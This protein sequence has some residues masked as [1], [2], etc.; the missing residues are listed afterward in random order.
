MIRALAALTTRNR[1][2]DPGAKASIF[3]PARALTLFTAPSRPCRMTS[4]GIVEIADDLA[5]IVE[6]PVVQDQKL[7]GIGED[8]P[9]LIDDHRA[10]QSTPQLLAGN[11]LDQRLVEKGPGIGRR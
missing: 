5:G 6:P 3:V 11:R 8:R 7:V 4:A 9:G 2:R 10:G 1:S